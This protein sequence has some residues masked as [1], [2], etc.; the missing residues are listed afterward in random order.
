[1]NQKEI[2]RLISVVKKSEKNLRKALLRLNENGTPVYWR[3]QRDREG[4]IEVITT[5]LVVA[6]KEGCSRAFLS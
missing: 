1:M 4:T 2:R 6:D 5:D 3:R